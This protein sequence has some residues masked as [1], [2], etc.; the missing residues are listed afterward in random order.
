MPT[1]YIVAVLVAGFLLAGLLGYARLLRQSVLTEFRESLREAK[2]S[3]DLPEE[4]KE[5]EIE[6]ATPE[7]FNTEMSASAIR[8]YET[9]EIIERFWYVWLVLLIVI[10]CGVASLLPSVP[11]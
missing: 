3:G 2:E 8:N 11:E 9:A 4:L 6:T 5:L 10:C 1:R 7:D